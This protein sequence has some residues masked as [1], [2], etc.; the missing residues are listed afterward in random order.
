MSYVEIFGGSDIMKVTENLA[1]LFVFIITFKVHIFFIIVKTLSMRIIVSHY[2]HICT[3]TCQT[4]QVGEIY[5]E[6]LLSTVFFLVLLTLSELNRF[7]RK[8]Y[9]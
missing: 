4:N 2:F 1:I 9:C 3:N 8:L 7:S 6:S 5:F